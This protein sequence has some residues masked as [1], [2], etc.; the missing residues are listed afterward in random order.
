ML[1]NRMNDRND[2]NHYNNL[3]SSN[4]IKVLAIRLRLRQDKRKISKLYNTS[5]NHCIEFTSVLMP[6]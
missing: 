5:V 4:K 2:N 6:F 1:N 3:C